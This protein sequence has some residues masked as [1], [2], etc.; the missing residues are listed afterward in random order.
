LVGLNVDYLV[1][2]ATARDIVLWNLFDV[3][4]ERATYD[5]DVAVCALS[6]EHYSA[7]ITAVLASGFFTQGRSPHVLLFQPPDL[8]RA[9]PLDIIPFGELAD[10][11]G[12]I[13]WP[14]D[15]EVVMG[16]QG[17]EEAIRHALRVRIAQDV[18][19][20]VTSPAAPVILKVIAWSE[21][22]ATKKHRCAGY[23]P[24]REQLRHG[25][26]GQNLGRRGHDDHGGLRLRSVAYCGKIIGEAGPRNCRRRDTH[27]ARDLAEGRRGI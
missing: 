19:V 12:K 9:V 21:R 17:F 24:Y 13:R 26:W 18:V 6:W 5:V 14:P 16:V 22:G 23:P 20:S 1:A 27:N 3:K 10:H 8:K 2:G 15:G 25:A 11:D 4:E 7:A